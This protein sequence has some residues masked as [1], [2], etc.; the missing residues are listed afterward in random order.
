MAERKQVNLNLGKVSATPSM[1]AVGGTNQVAV[2]S[3]LKDNAAMRL[4]RSL[5]Q[6]SNILG[7][8]SNINMQR[9]KD[10]AEKLSAEEI[11]DIIEGKVPAPTGGALG[12][13]GFQKAFH[14]IAAKRWFD[15]TGVQKYA[16]VENRINAKMDEFI[17]SSTPIEQVQA[18]VQNEL[19]TLEGEIGEYFEGNSFGSRVK[20][21]IGS[22]LS[23]RIT[24]GATKGYEQKQLAYM[25]AVEEEKRLN[26]FSGVV[27]GESNE[28]LNGYFTRM[29][30]LYKE[31]GYS[32]EKIN[33]IINSTFIKGLNLAMATD[34]DIALGMLSQAK[35]V[36]INGQPALG[37]MAT[38]Q[39]MA[40]ARG[41]ISKLQAAAEED[42]FTLSEI[43]QQV[44]G[45]AGKFFEILKGYN[46][47]G[48]SPPKEGGMAYNYLLQSFRVLNRE[49]ALTDVG[50]KPEDLTN[51]IM[52]YDN[53]QDGWD[54][55][56]AKLINIEGL[57]SQTRASLNITLGTISDERR[58][59]NQAPPKI[60]T[61]I[62][63][64]TKKELQEEAKIWFETNSGTAEDFMRQSEFPELE[65]PQGV[66]NEENKSKL[67]NKYLPED[68][69]LDLLLDQEIDAVR[70]DPNL[71]SVFKGTDNI[72]PVYFKTRIE[73]DKFEA[74]QRVIKELKD[75]AKKNIFENTPNKETLMQ[76]KA[77]SLIKEETESLRFLATTI[78]VRNEEDFGDD[79]FDAE[80]DPQ[81]IKASRV[82]KKESFL[83]KP[84]DDPDDSPFFSKQSWGNWQADNTRFKKYK[85]LDREYAT[86]VVEG[87]T[88]LTEIST[89]RVI[90]T[91]FKKARDT[92]DTEALELLMKFYGY[93]GIDF[94][95]PKF[96]QD[97][98]DT[99][100]WWDEVSLFENFAA[101][102]ETFKTF[103]EL[104]LKVDE[105]AELT[106]DDRKKL[107][108]MADLGIYDETEESVFIQ[109][110]L[111]VQ[112]ELLTAD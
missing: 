70:E 112:T 27:L 56:T 71:E 10:A 13:L 23:T 76:E 53:P 51:A 45:T 108:V 60:Y 89:R 103:T 91:D 97:F 93:K 40:E 80:I 41:K 30:K 102:D 17:Q 61:G 82:E 1:Q 48:Q 95:N 57:D 8:T 6:F 43:N 19:Q 44:T 62:P 16:E 2:Q 14:Q 107:A 46:D 85:A 64:S 20:N 79:G 87:K 11:N 100:L 3:V 94:T 73:A 52:S 77:K 69:V 32:G 33:T 21:L 67:Y 84:E 65:P 68:S 5:S 96:I 34:P 81:K 25:R 42:E 12:K 74:K 59:I 38:R 35:K 39:A 72:T 105:D 9:G 99:A 22:E 75:F 18:Y 26:E 101:L 88:P 55:E 54:K 90:D 15:T 83:L 28:N 24:A 31:D 36:K 98:D 63:L 111:D 110:F 109:N 78:Q 58:K 4:S 49:G 66:K 47:K 50:I 7:Q 29:Q 106:E 92:D 104:M 37:S 86:S